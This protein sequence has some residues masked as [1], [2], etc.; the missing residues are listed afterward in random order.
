MRTRDSD[1]HPK[2]NDWFHFRWVENFSAAYAFA[3]FLSFRMCP[4]SNEVLAISCFG[5]LSLATAKTNHARS[6]TCCYHETVS[7]FSLPISIRVEPSLVSHSVII[8]RN[9]DSNLLYLFALSRSFL[10]SG[11]ILLSFGVCVSGARLWHNQSSVCVC[12]LGT[13]ESNTTPIEIEC[14]A[15]ILATL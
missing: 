12:V 2:I 3:L 9:H 7:F 13:R 14:S 1:I 5:L 8:T 11:R 10:V 4:N 15:R 6:P